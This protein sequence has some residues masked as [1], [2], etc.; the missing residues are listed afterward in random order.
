MLIFTRRVNET[1][2][3]NDKILVTILR[4]QG[5]QVK[6]GIDAPKKISVH[7]KE[8]YKLINKKI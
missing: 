3:I 7:R 1:V 6:I 8:I 5:N 2:I 4:I